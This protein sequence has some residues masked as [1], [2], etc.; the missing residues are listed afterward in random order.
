MQMHASCHLLRRKKKKKQKRKRP[1]GPSTLPRLSSL[2]MEVTQEKS[3]C[4]W[5]PCRQPVQHVYLWWQLLK[6][7]EIYLQTPWESLMAQRI[8]NSDR[9]I[10]ISTVLVLRRHS[11]PRGGGALRGMRCHPF[12]PTGAALSF[13]GLRSCSPGGQPAA[14]HKLTGLVL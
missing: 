6:Y 9:D 13:Q 4:L 14:L 3:K 1:F 10:N 11:T 7:R 12:L 5:A 2:C 8:L